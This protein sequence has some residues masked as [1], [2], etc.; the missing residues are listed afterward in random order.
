MGMEFDLKNIQG[1]LG[2]L[3]GLGNIGG[4]MGQAKHMLAGLNLEDISSMI[5]DVDPEELKGIIDRMPPQMMEMVEGMGITKEEISEAAK[6][7]P[8]HMDEI[9]GMM[10][11]VNNG[12]LKKI[13]KNELQNMG[14]E[15]PEEED[16]DNVMKTLSAQAKDKLT[17]FG[18]DIEDL[19][20][21]KG[22]MPKILDLLKGQ[23][24]AEGIEIDP[25]NPES[26][27]AQLE[28]LLRAHFELADDATP[29]EMRSK[30]MNKM[31]GY[32]EDLGI[33]VADEDMETPEKAMGALKKKFISTAN[34][35]GFE[36]KDDS[37]FEEI[38]EAVMSKM[39]NSGIMEN[40]MQY[41]PMLLNGLKSLGGIFN[42]GGEEQQPMMEISP[43]QQM[44]MERQMMM[45]QR[46]MMM[47]RRPMPMNMN[48]EINIDG[49]NAYRPPTA[50]PAYLRGAEDAL[51][52]AYGDDTEV[53]RHVMTVQ[54]GIR[55]GAVSE[56]AVHELLTDLM[57]A[58]LQARVLASRNA[59][60][61]QQVM[62]DQ[63]EARIPVS[64]SPFLNHIRHKCKH[65]RNLA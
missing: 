3:G 44:M 26:I 28:T 48:F 18:L 11:S 23:L 14:M 32:L 38:K 25:E 65:G 46:Q 60:L 4:L 6:H 58:R 5:K 35:Y 47:Q 16:M 59:M 52:H 64:R 36:F 49:Q 40:P 13:M 53:V 12:D 17:E 9:K 31:R 33:E 19:K 55:Q 43:E 50:F 8:E 56:E 22:A 42:M 63:F 34:G 30:V 29:E 21:V 61:E 57:H 10:G 20:D 1:M 45:Q 2:G 27:K 51:M 37:S 24:M 7:L 54:Q 15:I 41:L 39:K 62:H